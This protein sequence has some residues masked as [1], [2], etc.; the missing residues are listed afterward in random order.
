M[1]GAWGTRLLGNIRLNIILGVSVRIFLDKRNIWIGSMSETDCPLHCGL[2]SPNPLKKVKLENSLSLPV[3][4]W[5]HHFSCFQTWTRTGIS[6][7][8]SCTQTWARVYTLRSS[9]SQTARLHKTHTAYT[10]FCPWGFPGKNTRVGCFSR[11]SLW[12]RDQTY[13]SCIGRQILYH[14]ATREAQNNKW[15]KT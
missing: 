2:V 9:E 3:L 4:K 14:W 5:G 13:V 8:S 15:H 11:G 12:P 10:P 1:I 6:T 7:I